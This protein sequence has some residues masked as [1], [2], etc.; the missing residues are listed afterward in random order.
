MYNYA[1]ERCSRCVDLESDGIMGSLD[2]KIVPQM[3]CRFLKLVAPFT[4]P[5]MRDQVNAI[6]EMGWVLNGI[7]PIDGDDWAVFTRP[8][9]QT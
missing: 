5:G 3:A 2:Q 7:Y 6:L 4:G 8:K 9:K 1:H